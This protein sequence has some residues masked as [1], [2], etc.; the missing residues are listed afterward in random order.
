MILSMCYGIQQLTRLTMLL[1]AFTLLN[2]QT[3][4]PATR[5]RKMFLLRL[6]ALSIPSQQLQ[7][8]RAAVM[9]ALH[10]WISV[11]AS[12]ISF[13]V[14]VA[15]VDQRGVGRHRFLAMFL[16]MRIL[17]LLVLVCHMET[18]SSCQW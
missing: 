6:K 3:M 1:S 15:L 12:G 2:Q 11:Q 16:V 13:I 10:G 18:I 8:A 9:F 7:Q 17:H 5:S 14:P 4:A